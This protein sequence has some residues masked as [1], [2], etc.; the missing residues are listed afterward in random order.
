MAVTI[1]FGGGGV[2]VG[3]GL[4]VTANTTLTSGLNYLT[5]GPTTIGSGVIVTVNSGVTYVVI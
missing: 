3:A 4:T 5:I 2:F 1:G